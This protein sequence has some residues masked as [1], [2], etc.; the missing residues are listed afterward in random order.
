[1]VGE[2]KERKEKNRASL[3]VDEHELVTELPS[4]S[5]SLQSV[6]GEV[7]NIASFEE[8]MSFADVKYD[9]PLSPKHTICECTHADFV[10]KVKSKEQRAQENRASLYWEDDVQVEKIGYDIP[11]SPKHVAGESLN[12]KFIQE[13][14]ELTED[15]KRASLFMEEDTTFSRVTKGAAV[16]MHVAHE[17]VNKES[18]EE[19][20]ERE[21]GELEKRSSEFMAEDLVIN[22]VIQ[23]TVSSPKHVIGESQTVDSF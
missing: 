17:R 4:E 8:V 16:S 10:E 19:I 9:T 23:D 20:I 14:T 7:E 21:P 5:L 13:V 6:A 15:E 3:I 2:V 18:M 12:T 22:E 1:M 11:A